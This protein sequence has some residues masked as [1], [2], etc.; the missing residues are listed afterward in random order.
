MKAHA[1]AAILA[2]LALAATG[3]FLA[4]DQ[5]SPYADAIADGDSGDIHWDLAAGVLTLT[6]KPGNVGT[7]ME[8]YV[9]DSDAPWYAHR[10]SVA[11]VVIGDGITSIG[12]RAFASSALSSVSIPGSVTSIGDY[13]FAYCLSLAAID[14]QSVTYIGS[15]AFFS[16]FSLATIDIPSGMT[17]ISERTFELCWG[18]TSIIIP[19]SVTYIGSGAFTRCYGI[20]SVDIGVGVQTIDEGA[21][22]MCWGLSLVTFHGTV[23]HIRGTVFWDD[24]QLR[25]IVFEGSAPTDLGD[26]SFCLSR[27]QATVETYVWSTTDFTDDLLA[28]AEGGGFYVYTYTTIYYGGAVGGAGYP[29]LLPEEMENHNDVTGQITWSYVKGTKTLTLSGTGVST[30]PTDGPWHDYRLYTKHLVIGDGIRILNGRAFKQYLNLESVE[31]SDSVVT[32]GANAFAHCINLKSVTITGN[33]LQYIQDNAFFRCIKLESI[34]IPSSVT[35]IQSMAFFDS[36]SLSSVTIMNPNMTT[37]AEDAFSSNTD[38]ANTVILIYNPDAGGGTGTLYDPEGASLNATVAY[39]DLIGTPYATKTRDG[40]MSL[41]GFSGAVQAGTTAWDADVATVFEGYPFAVPAGAVLYL[42]EGETYSVGVTVGSNGT[43]GYEI[44]SEEP[45]GVLTEIGLTGTQNI[46]VPAGWSLLLTGSPSGG[47]Q[48]EKWNDGE[49]DLAY[50]PISASEAG[51]YEVSFNQVGSPGSGYVVT[52]TAEAHGKVL[53]APSGDTPAG[54][55]AG[56]ADIHLGDGETVTLTG[57]AV[58]THYAFEKWTRSLPSAATFAY[59]PVVVSSAGEYEVSFFDSTNPANG[60]NVTVTAGYGGKALYATSDSAAS[61]ETA[62]MATVHVNSGRAVVLTGVATVP[63]YVFEQWTRSAPSAAASAANPLTVSSAG[64][65]A[66]A[67]LGPLYTVSAS[68]DSNSTITPAGSVSVSGGSSAMFS[69]SAN[70]GYAI[71]DVVVDGASVPSAAASGTYAFSGVASNHTISVTSAP[72][73]SSSGGS[74]SGSGSGN[75]SGDG[76]GDGA[77]E[78]RAGDGDDGV[79]V[80]AVL[81][82]VVAAIAVGSAVLWLLLRRR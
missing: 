73:A 53:Y 16:C 60:Y 36:F 28:A 47:Y 22:S 12:D 17:S 32:I 58:A 51:Q 20:E 7:D 23:E 78:S 66:A 41:Y 4:S 15:F 68:A 3:A 59:D 79:S 26:G 65:Y 64:S 48:F 21:F 75:G 14:I 45:R 37:L 24:Q 2:V 56:T 72:S 11:R 18:L 34:I 30:L 43:F 69:F 74:G 81:A 35:T 44:Y 1:Y 40:V 77:G 33:A 29:N 55:I 5:N 71:S 63:N 25:N 8:D 50:N 38:G 10:A 80:V 52:V 31:L 9:A 62:G 49:D 67:F 46:S 57:I 19:D 27:G 82:V 76:S 54:E 13:A 6:L 70:A 61:G 42:S 39:F